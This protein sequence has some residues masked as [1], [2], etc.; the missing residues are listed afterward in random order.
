MYEEI[1]I[2][3][4]IFL[5]KINDIAKLNNIHIKHNQILNK[6]KISASADMDVIYYTK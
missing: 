3:M 6:Y 1:S 2:I 5:Y 4:V